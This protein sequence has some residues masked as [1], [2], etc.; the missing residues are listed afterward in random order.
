MILSCIQNNTSMLATDVKLGSGIATSL[1]PRP[2][3][4]E[5][6]GPGTYASAFT[7][8]LKKIWGAINDCTLFHPSLMDKGTR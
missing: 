8:Y 4:R 3:E 2:F 1:V 7:N 5:E 6:K